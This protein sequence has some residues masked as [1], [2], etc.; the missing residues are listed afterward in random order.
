MGQNNGEEM[1]WGIG[2][3]VE[4]SG[5]WHVGRMSDHHEESKGSGLSLARKTRVPVLH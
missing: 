4:R 2:C 1:D 5:M 3:S